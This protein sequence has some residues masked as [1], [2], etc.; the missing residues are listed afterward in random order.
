MSDT[1]YITGPIPDGYQIYSEQFSIA[2][3]HLRKYE[4]QSFIG[5]NDRTLS[6]EPEPHNTKDPNAIKILGT[7]KG[8]FFTST[9]VLGYVPKEIA[10]QID[11]L[12]SNGSTLPELSLDIDFVVDELLKLKPDLSRG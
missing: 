1:E 10:A 5:R 6:L 8:W 3:L 7:S 9:V 4:A 12:L 2:G 11:S